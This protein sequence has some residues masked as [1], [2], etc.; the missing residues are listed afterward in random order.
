M[1]ARH[2]PETPHPYAHE[3][4]YVSDAWREQQAEMRAEMQRR[5]RFCIECRTT[6][7]HAQGCPADEDFDDEGEQQ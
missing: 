6:G 1:S 3:V 2:T 7:G 4:E 5:P